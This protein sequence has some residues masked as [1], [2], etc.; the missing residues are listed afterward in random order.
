MLE[1]SK[2]NFKEEMVKIGKMS[3]IR[4]IGSNNLNVQCTYCKKWRHTIATV[5]F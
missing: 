5:Y 4:V 2:D 3:K 1:I